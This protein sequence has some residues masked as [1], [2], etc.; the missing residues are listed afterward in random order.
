MT[1]FTPLLA[2]DEEVVAAVSIVFISSWIGI[3]FVTRLV[4][5]GRR[6]ARAA[7]YAADA[8]ENQDRLKALMIQ[9]GMGAE[10][11]ERVLAQDSVGGIGE[12]NDAEAKMI[13][14]LTTNGYKASDVARI[15]TAAKN[16]SGF[17][18]EPA[19]AMVEGLAWNWT[20]ASKI[21]RALDER[22][23][24]AHHRERHNRVC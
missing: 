18:D 2:N 7:Q 17:V 4:L 13:R 12:Q 8:R 22:H 19:A 9:R 1:E 24:R 5:D 16:N 20:S 21:I 3:Y 14:T 10:E 6:R 23:G 11:I 15:A